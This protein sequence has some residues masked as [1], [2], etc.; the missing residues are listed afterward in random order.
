[1]QA[2]AGGRADYIAAAM[3]R[4]QVSS[5]LPVLAITRQ[6]GG[7]KVMGELST[8]GWKAFMVPSEFLAHG[9]WLTLYI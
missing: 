1:V 7:W 6:L 5:F 3:L 2:F 8:Y 9:P 4:E